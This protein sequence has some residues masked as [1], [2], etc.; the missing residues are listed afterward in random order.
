MDLQAIS[1]PTMIS[2]LNGRRG[3]PGGT[4]YTNCV[5]MRVQEFSEKGTFFKL[6]SSSDLSRSEEKVPFR[7]KGINSLL[8]LLI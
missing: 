4:T 3:K 5:N 1:A 7:D 2:L 6:K 8:F